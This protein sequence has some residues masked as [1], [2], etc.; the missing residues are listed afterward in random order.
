MLSNIRMTAYAWIAQVI[1]LTM[2]L[3]T[4]ASIIIEYEP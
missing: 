1:A 4:A 3:A 2:L